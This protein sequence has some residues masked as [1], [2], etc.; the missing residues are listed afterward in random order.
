MNLFDAKLS[1]R[2]M[3]AATGA[4]I[5]PAILSKSALATLADN[6]SVDG[7]PDEFYFEETTA[8]G[9]RA[10]E[11]GV[12]FLLK[13]LNRDGSCGVDI[14][15]AP[16]IGCSCMMGLALQSMGNTPIEGPRS[17]ELRRIQSFVIQQTENMPSDDITNAQNTQLQ[18]K[19]GRHAHSFF[20]ALFLSQIVG[21]G[22]NPEP[23]RVALRRVVDAVVKAQTAQGDWGSSS[24]APTLG[25]VMGWVCLRAADFA[26]MKVGTAPEKTAEHLIKKMQSSLKENRG[27]MHELYKNAT[28]I[29]VLYAMKM[30]E[31]EVA[32]RAF[33]SVLELVNNK[34]AQSF[35]QA[36]GEEFLAFHLITETMLQKGGSDWKKWYPGVRDNLVKV[37]NRDG[38]WTGHHCITSRTFC[39]AAAIL[40]LTAPNRYLP[41]SQL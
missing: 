17:N 15:Q 8:A 5:P 13:V 33:K 11:R 37:Q 12:D 6:D 32:Q 28:G 19:I 35:T 21:E 38:S 34:N 30:E 40:V 31:E 24:W 9:D 20:A 18:R 26:G 39:T 16:D 22:S 3:L 25:T 36:G 29:R 14:G 2:S 7:N 4:L 1:R 41:I 10:V 27:W 23:S